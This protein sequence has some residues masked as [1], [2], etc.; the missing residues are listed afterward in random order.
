MIT[1]KQAALT[2]INE[3]LSALEYEPIEQLDIDG[4]I[5]ETRD[6]LLDARSELTSLPWPMMRAFT[7]LEREAWLKARIIEQEADGR[8]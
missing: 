5:D 2:M 4:H 1:P 7:L 3:A 8:Q 6:I